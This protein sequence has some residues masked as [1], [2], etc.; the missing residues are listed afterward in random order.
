ML[1]EAWVW[2]KGNAPEGQACIGEVWSSLEQAFE[3]VF[4]MNRRCI[5]ENL[6]RFYFVKSIKEE[7]KQE[8]SN[9]EFLKMMSKQFIG[10]NHKDL[11][12]LEKNL[13]KMFYDLCY[14]YIN[15]DGNICETKNS[16]YE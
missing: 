6:S 14:I 8:P 1:Y 7:K 15:E 4:L 13:Y 11:T 5:E 9:S 12:E 16:I 3:F 2:Q 10:I